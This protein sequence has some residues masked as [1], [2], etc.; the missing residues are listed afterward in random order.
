VLPDLVVTTDVMAGFPGETV[1]QAAETLEFCERMGFG[2]LHVFRY[3]RRVGT[4]AA[5]RP[6]QVPE[7]E[8]SRRAEA[9]RDLGERLA[10]TRAAARVGDL[11]EVLVERVGGPEGA[12]FGE[13]TTRDYLRVRFSAA[14]VS[15]GDLVRVRLGQRHGDRVFAERVD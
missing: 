8:K 5:A 9:L 2:K 11:G 3:S 6:D 15:P 7:S 12:R 1:E 10:A 4:P 13:G 14:G